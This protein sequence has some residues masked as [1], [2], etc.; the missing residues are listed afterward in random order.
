MSGVH[1]YLAT[2]L[3]AQLFKI[4]TEHVKIKLLDVLLKVNSLN[5]VQYH[6]ARV[7]VW[8]CSFYTIYYNIV[9]VNSER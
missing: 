3:V 8:H 4:G 7:S 2:T 6:Y 5:L 1:G 9:F